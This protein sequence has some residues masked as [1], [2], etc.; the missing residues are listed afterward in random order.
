M[1][2]FGL[3]WLAAAIGCFGMFL[4]GRKKKQGFIWLTIGSIGWICVGMSTATFGLVAASLIRCGIEV[5][6]WYKWR[7]EDGTKP[8]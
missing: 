6:D 1:I 7:R 4:L 8:K 3:D 2:L 5:Y